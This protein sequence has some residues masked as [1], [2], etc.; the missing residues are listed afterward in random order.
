[1]IQ[2][3][4]KMARRSLG[5]NKWYSAIT[6]VGLAMA[7]T[8]VLLI[9]L[10]IN[11]E[12]S[13]DRFN[14]KADRIYRVNSD[15]S[16]SLQGL[17]TAAAPT[18]LGGTLKREFPEVEEAVRLGLYQ[19]CLV[20][21]TQENIREQAILLAD[22]TLFNV[23]TLPVLAGNPKTALAQPN[24]VVIT[25]RMA[26]K[27]F[28]TANA[29]NKVLI[30][31][32]QE[33]RQVSAVIK[34]LP[35]Q[36]HFQADFILPL[37]ETNNAKVDKWGNHIFNTYIL[38]RPGTDPGAVEAKFETI[39][40][41]Y[42][43]PALRRF[44]NTSLAETRKKGNYFRYSL[45][46]L[47]GIHLYSARAG[48]LMPNGSIEYVYI[49]TGIGLFILMIAVVNFVN[50]TTARSIKRARE[51]GVRKVLGSNRKGLISQFLSES[52]LIAFISMLCALVMVL[53]LLPLFNT[54]TAETVSVSELL[55]IPGALG[56]FSFTAL[57]G[58]MAGIYPAFYLSSFQPA[59]AI[60]GILGS[61]PN[62]QNLRSSLV[63]F[64]FA[65]SVLLIIGTL[66]INQQMQFIQRKNLGFEKE[67]ILILK[68]T[69]VPDNQLRTFKEIALQNSK[70]KAAT[71]SSFLPVTS[72]R[73]GDYWYPEG[74][75]DQKYSVIMQEWEVD[76]DYLATYKMKLLQGRYFVKGQVTDSAR[77]VINESAARQLGYKQPV[78]KIIHKQGG[79]QLTIIGVVKDFHYESL[80][81][82]IEPLCF[83]LDT[84]IVAGKNSDALSLRLET[85]DMV[86]LLSVLESKWKKIAP[87][88]PF[89]YSFLNEN[90]DDMYRTEHRVQVL[91]TVFTTIAILISC[92]GLFGLATFTAEQR[93]KEIGVRKV[94]GAS[95]ASI[96]TLLSRD[97]LKPV[98]FAILIASPVAWYMMDRWLQD[99]SYRISIEWW[100][101]VLAATLAIGIALITVSLQSIRAAL[102]NPVRSLKSD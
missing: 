90:F 13:F 76:D 91:F 78:G 25:E 23:F 59:T 51:I 34:D 3:H 75:N 48:E 32:N 45:M 18:P 20:K 67:Q 81:T 87:G 8:V 26:K 98:L 28:G 96:V 94:L 97:F 73:S 12:L 19:S 37:W 62:G 93:T 53:V 68:T 80:R 72:K 82:K 44:F 16:F 102:M 71:I 69:E 10:Y 63:V 83:M 99:F 43:D 41:T 38:L 65:M 89:D 5:Q 74:Q 50:L 46:P 52:M 42:M 55:S 95:V 6:I 47:T 92:L 11:N 35:A 30:F 88:Q 54:L 57:I 33:S 61:L 58:I 56:L 15:I 31:N 70:V 27:Y 100:V 66:L 101:F 17:Q 79:D 22:S 40:Q 14:Q 7:L 36:S 39:L 24:S 4:I 1:M 2:N 60:K 29:L 21:S 9:G 86:S 64:Q 85:E 84:D 49:F 77:V